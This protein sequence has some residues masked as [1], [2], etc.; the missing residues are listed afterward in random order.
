MIQ[1]V[2]CLFAVLNGHFTTI[3]RYGNYDA[4]AGAAKPLLEYV[5]H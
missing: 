2:K 4:Y 5:F 1:A 3:P